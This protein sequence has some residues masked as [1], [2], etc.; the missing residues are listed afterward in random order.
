M[1]IQ[2]EQQCVSEPKAEPEFNSFYTGKGENQGEEIPEINLPIY[3]KLYPNL[4][5]C[6]TRN[7]PG[8]TPGT[9]EYPG[10][11]QTRTQSLFKCFL[12][13]R[14]DWGLVLGARGVSW[15]GKKEI[16]LSSLPMRPRA[17]LNVIPNLLSSQKTL[18]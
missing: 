18:K 12:G 5:V 10:S 15:E 17:R 2:L 14:E 8:N 6:K 13:M 4:G 3:Q 7:M 1:Y 16:F 11:P 9:P